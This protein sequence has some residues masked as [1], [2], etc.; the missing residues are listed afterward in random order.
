MKRNKKRKF[1]FYWFFRSFKVTCII[2]FCSILLSLGFLEG[3]ARMES[4]IT[5]D[6]IELIENKNDRFYLLNRDVCSA[7]FIKFLKYVKS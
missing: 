6:R 1:K 7:K 2:L 3:Y 5:G 4:K